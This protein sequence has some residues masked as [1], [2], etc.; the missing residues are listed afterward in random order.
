MLEEGEKMCDPS[1]IPKV[2]SIDPDYHGAP[3]LVSA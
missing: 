2:G 1:A 3:N